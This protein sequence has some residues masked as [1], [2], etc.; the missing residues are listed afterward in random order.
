LQQARVR[1]I[2]VH[3]VE[4]GPPGAFLM[5]RCEQALREADHAMAGG[6]IV[7]ILRA[8]VALT[9]FSE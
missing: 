4:I 3:A 5:A 9:E 1:R 8:Y 2:L 6:D 7:R